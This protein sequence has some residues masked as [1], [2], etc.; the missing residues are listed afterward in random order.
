VTPTFTLTY[1]AA[2]T[3]TPSLTFTPSLT[4]TPSLTF[5]PSI[6]FTPTIAPTVNP[7]SAKI[8]LN[9]RARLR[10]TP[11]TAGKALGWLE[12]EAEV[13]M[14]GRSEDGT[15]A[16]VI[17]VKDNKHGWVSTHFLR[18]QEGVDLAVLIVSGVP[19]EASITP[20]FKNG[21]SLVVSNVSGHAHQIFLKGQSLGNHPNVFSRVGDS[22]SASPYFLTPIGMGQC[23]LGDYHNQFIDVIGYF[24]SGIARD[25]NNSFMNWSLAA[26]NGWGADRI[27][28]P[29][30]ANQG[31]CGNDSPLVCEYKVVKPSVALIMVGTNDSGGISPEAFK[32]NLDQ[33]IQISIDMGVIPIISTI[34]P[35]LNDAWNRDRANQWNGIIRATARQWDVPLW[36]YWAAL[37]AAPNQGISADGIHPSVPPSGK[38]CDFSSDGLQYGYTIRNLTAL[39]VLDSIW[40]L[41]IY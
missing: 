31:I 11:G 34:P 36:D 32:A 20:T 27:I 25:G 41:A 23:N 29:G 35:K 1:T 3:L 19:I 14:I 28:Q 22:I 4:L 6:T 10:E 5:T 17:V 26:G 18:W 33:I 39:Q 40:R 2:P 12:S 9:C 30:F 38:T 7:I 24:L 37:Q 21:Q 16:E 13:N 8:C 15:W